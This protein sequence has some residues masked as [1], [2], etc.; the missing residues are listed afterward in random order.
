[1]GSDLEFDFEGSMLPGLQRFYA[2]FG[3]KPYLYMRLTHNRLPF[4]LN[5]LLHV[6]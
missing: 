1:V 4:P 6:G 3:A 5:R 2:G